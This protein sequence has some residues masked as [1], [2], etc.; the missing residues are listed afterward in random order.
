MIVLD[1]NVAVAMLLDAEDSHAFRSL[2]LVD[3]E[4]ISSELLLA[5]IESALG[6]Y[7]RADRL[8]YD[9][10]LWSLKNLGDIVTRFV[11]IGENYVEAF[12]EAQRLNHSVY[13]M[14]YFTLARR[15]AATLFTLDRKLLQLCEQEGVDCVHMLASKEY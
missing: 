12:R 7:V 11:D 4:I 1:C 3:E 14:I 10:A 15:N 9:T 5:E 2:L 8:N 13:D 6:K